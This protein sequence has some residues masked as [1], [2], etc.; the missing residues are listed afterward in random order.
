MTGWTRVT[1][2]LPD[3]P[4]PEIWDH[5]AESAE[6]LVCTPTGSRYIAVLRTINDDDAA[7]ANPPRDWR[8]IGGDGYTLALHDVTHWH[9]LPAAPDPTERLRAQMAAHPVVGPMP[10]PGEPEYHEDDEAPPTF[11]ARADN[12]YNYE[13]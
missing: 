1:E 3:C 7:P 10:L 8:L 9:T 6:L 5:A 12:P 13:D 2:R 11:H 4:S